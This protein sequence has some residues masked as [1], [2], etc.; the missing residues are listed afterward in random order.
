MGRDFGMLNVSHY[1]LRPFILL[2]LSL[3]LKILPNL[4]HMKKGLLLLCCY[5]AMSFSTWQPN[6]ET[7]QT[8]AKEKGRLILLNFSGSDWCG[9]CIRMHREIFAS[10][11]FSKMSDTA[12]VMVN[13]DFPRSK[14]HQLNKD[15]Q[16]ENDALAEKYNPEGKF[17]FT[18]LLDENGKVLKTWDGLPAEN[19]DAFAAIIKN[20]CD[21][22]AKP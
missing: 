9:P 17:P 3:L 5:A 2:V 10:E 1:P 4:T 12:L 15:L 18:L 11:V 8:I 16:K 21:A 6:F 14:K 13:A 7:A 20:I 19:A 22:Y